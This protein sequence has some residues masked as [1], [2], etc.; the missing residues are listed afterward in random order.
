MTNTD[1]VTSYYIRTIA[2]SQPGCFIDVHYG[3]VYKPDKW[4]TQTGSYGAAFPAKQF[5]TVHQQILIPTAVCNWNAKRSEQQIVSTALQMKARIVYP[6]TLLGHVL[7]AL[8]IA[9]GPT[10]STI[11]RVPE[12][13]SFEVKGR[14]MYL[15]I[16]LNRAR[17]RL[18][19][20]PESL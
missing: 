5:Q 15:T 19:E 16:F 6:V 9:V 11:Q 8:P 20:A 12:A 2:R 13:L 10:Y 4:Q 17:R 18:S 14:G 7:K 1:Y 3:V